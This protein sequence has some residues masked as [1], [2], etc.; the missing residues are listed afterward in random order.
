M[1]AVRSEELAMRF[2]HKRPYHVLDDSPASL[3]KPPRSW[4]ENEV[5]ILVSSLSKHHRAVTASCGVIAYVI[6]CGAI[7]LLA[8]IAKG[9][10]SGYE[11][12]YFIDKVPVEKTD[13]YGH[14]ELVDRKA[15]VPSS[16]LLE[17]LI[18]GTAVGVAGVIGA[19]RHH[20]KR[21]VIIPVIG[22]FPVLLA[23][24]AILAL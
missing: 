5:H 21:L 24:L 14:R 23:W 4:L 13:Q 12:F 15:I 16:Q 17:L 19:S 10:R 3:S 9:D 18:I 6:G 8:N 22:L 20:R 2:A 7:F 11:R 1:E